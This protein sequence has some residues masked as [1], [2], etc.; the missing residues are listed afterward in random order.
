MEQVTDTHQTFKNSPFGALRSSIESVLS[1]VSE[2]FTS[3]RIA[4]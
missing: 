2:V 4:A 1:S 3:M